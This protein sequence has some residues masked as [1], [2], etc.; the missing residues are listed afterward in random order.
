MEAAG[1]ALDRGN[2]LDISY[3]IRHKNGKLIWVH[4][5]GR[6]IETAQGDIGFYAVF[7]GMSAE[8]RLIQSI[9]NET[10]DGIYVI[11]KK[12]MSFSM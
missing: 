12:P 11:D 2:I 1:T 10:V 8:T 4:L 3:R 5:N 7:T 9:A 6:R